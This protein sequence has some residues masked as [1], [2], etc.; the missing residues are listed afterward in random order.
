MDIVIFR[1]FNI[2]LIIIISKIDSNNN[3]ENKSVS[4]LESFYKVKLEIFY[5]LLTLLDF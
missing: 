1:H 2:L 3:L 4:K 5:A